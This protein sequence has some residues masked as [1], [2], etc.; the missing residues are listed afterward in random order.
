MSLVAKQNSYSLSLTFNKNTHRFT[1]PILSKGMLSNAAM[2]IAAAM[3]LNISPQLIT[4]LITLLKPPK[5]SGEQFYYKNHFYYS[6]CYN[7]NS[8]A[9]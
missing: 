9:M 8:V 7:A 3:L 1:L 4:E 2:S 6:D 5:Y